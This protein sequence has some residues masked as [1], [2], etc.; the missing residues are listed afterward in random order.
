MNAHGA[1]TLIS[2]RVPPPLNLSGRA[3][4]NSPQQQSGKLGGTGVSAVGAGVRYHEL[5]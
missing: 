4:V 5:P 2:G 1:A 3:A